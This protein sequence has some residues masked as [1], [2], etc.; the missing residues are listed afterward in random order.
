MTIR[1][2]NRTRLLVLIGVLALASAFVV[3]A[4]SADPSGLRRHADKQD[5]MVQ[6]GGDA[7]AEDGAV[8]IRRHRALRIKVAIPTPEP[9]SY[10][11]PDGASP[12]DLEIFTAW[13]FVF[14]NP[15]ECTDP[16]DGDDIG[17]PANVGVYHLD[18][19]VGWDDTL[20]LQAKVRV[21][22]PRFGGTHDLARPLHA[23]VHVA[24]APHGAAVEE[25]LLE[26]L[27]TPIGDP[28]FWWAALFK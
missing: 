3:T 15:E 28:S 16:C 10:N 12:G 5:V 25:I 7:Y 13:A 18:G 4:A 9:G 11:Y 19:R 8:L 24:V 17:G 21:G 26:Q 1:T 6:G 22:D 20:V 23:E 2:T 27:T 14:N